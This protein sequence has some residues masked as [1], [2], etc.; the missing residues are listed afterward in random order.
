MEADADTSRWPWRA[1]RP[2]LHTPLTAVS[3]HAIPAI[4]SLASFL[5]GNNS[6]SGL[7]RTFGPV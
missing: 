6:G 5:L 7:P 3:I 1:A 4:S 2:L